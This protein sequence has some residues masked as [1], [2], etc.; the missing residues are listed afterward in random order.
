MAAALSRIPPLPGDTDD[1]GRREHVR[2]RLR[3]LTGEWQDDLQRHMSQ[4]FDPIRERVV[5]RPDISTNLLESVTSQ[6]SALYDE[7]PVLA[8]ED[9]DA[10]A[11]MSSL[12]AD[13][14]WASI[15]STYQQVTLGV[16]ECHLRPTLGPKGVVLR[17][18]TPDVVDAEA[19]PDDP[20]MPILLTEARVRDLGAGQEWYWDRFDL[21]DLERPTY[22]VIR[23]RDGVDL[24]AE[25][26]GSLDYPAA[27]RLGD[28]T[29][30]LPYATYH[31]RRTGRLY[32]W[33]TGIETVEGTLTAAVLWSWWLHSVRDS[34]WA[35]RWTM[36]AALRGGSV[37]G[38]GAGAAATVSTD[39]SS[40]M[41]FRSDGERASIGQWNPPVD[42]LTLGTA[43]AEF[44]QRL[45]VHYDLSPADVQ[46]RTSTP[47]SGLSISLRR[48]AVRRVQGKV[49]P[50]FRRGDLQM[51]RIIA[52]ATHDAPAP[53]PA[54]G[55][56]I[57]YPGQPRSAEEIASTLG[58]HTMLIEAGLESRV[59]AYLDLHPGISREQAVE[60]LHRIADENRT[61]S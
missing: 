12:L 52:A 37:T 44:E 41:Q 38:R 59:D 36:D 13:A 22:R 2:L 4:N 48:E 42:P 19:S 15:G 8:H 28:G 16:R 3:L 56:S 23:A 7:Q 20:D 47:T 45:L 46:A 33:R 53:L 55:W 51:L 1:A 11:L 31:A 26:L 32:N 61:L 29:P 17:I 6:L 58:R 50:E 35:Q 34:A 25:I 39:P 60:Q 9:E 18:V 10:A 14:G 54:E 24:T 5:G 30:I 40:V 43:V 27:F 57:D 21:R 49:Q